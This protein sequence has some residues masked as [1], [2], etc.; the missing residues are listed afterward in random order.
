MNDKGI[1]DALE[2]GISSCLRSLQQS[3]PGLLLTAHQLKRVERDVKYVP[4]V[5]GAIA[6]V[7]GRSKSEFIYKNTMNVATKWDGEVKKMRMSCPNNELSIAQRSGRNR[8]ADENNGQIKSRAE[9]E[10]MRIGELCQILE[11]RLRFVISDE[12]KEAKQSEIKEQQRQE[13]EEIAAAKKKA[14]INKVVSDGMNGDCLESEV[15]GSA[16]NSKAESARDTT[17]MNDFDSITSSPIVRRRWFQRDPIQQS[18]SASPLDCQRK[19]DPNV[20][21]LSNTS[22]PASQSK[23]HCR[24]ADSINYSNA[25]SEDFLSQSMDSDCLDLKHHLGIDNEGSQNIYTRRHTQ[26]VT[27]TDGF[28]DGYQSSPRQSLGCNQKRSSEQDD[29]ASD[30]DESS[31]LSMYGDVVPGHFFR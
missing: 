16:T 3:S 15:E 28:N 29:F 30:S 7:L 20:D 10:R 23:Q 21:F 14:K 24:R 1:S 12:Y 26:K 13:R 25:T 11:R 5:A 27:S 2:N 17:A 9:E 31:F 6:S 4:S 18:S 8:A 22:S 19:G